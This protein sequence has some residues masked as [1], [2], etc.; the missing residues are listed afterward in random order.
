MPTLIG[1][2]VGLKF[3]LIR[4]VLYIELNSKMQQCNN[5]YLFKCFENDTLQ[6]SANVTIAFETLICFW[7]TVLVFIPQTTQIKQNV[8][9]YMRCIVYRCT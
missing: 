3:G 2:S 8:S 9:K 5:K 6:S 1:T 7:V 4:F